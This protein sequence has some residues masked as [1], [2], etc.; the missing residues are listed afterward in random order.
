M[1]VKTLEVHLNLAEIDSHVFNTLLTHGFLVH[2]NSTHLNFLFLLLFRICSSGILGFFF[3]KLLDKVWVFEQI[4][5]A[6]KP[7]L[8]RIQSKS[9]RQLVVKS[10]Q[11]VLELFIGWDHTGKD[12]LNKTETCSRLSK[13]IR[14]GLC[15]LVLLTL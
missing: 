1:R 2:V 11:E 8:A 6:L 12:F 10:L 9:D 3:D 4:T 13:L 15:V 5:D 7:S 14:E